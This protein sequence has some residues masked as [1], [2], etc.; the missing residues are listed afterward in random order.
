MNNVRRSAE[1]AGINNSEI[2]GNLVRDENVAYSKRD[3]FVSAGG[4]HTILEFASEEEA[5]NFSY[6][7]SRKI[8]KMFPDMELF[9]KIMP[10]DHSS[11]PK[12][13]INNLI[14]ELEIKKSL[15]RLS[16]HKG[17]FGIEKSL[18]AI[19]E[20]DEEI[21]AA[22]RSILK[23]NAEVDDTLFDDTYNVVKEF[24]NLGGS[25]GDN[26]Y[27]AVVHIDGN[28]MGNRVNE[29][30]DACM[31]EKLSWEAF[32]ERLDVFSEEIDKDF[33]AA[34]KE[35][36]A[37]I[38]ESLENGT[39]DQLDLI[40]NNFPV[41]RIISS[42]DD[43]CFVCDGRIGIEAAV[44]FIKA[45]TRRQNI[46]DQKRYAACAG[47]A[48][49][50]AKYPFYRAYQLAED[51]C[52]NAKKVGAEI[53]EEVA[54]NDKK[55]SGACISAIDWHIEQGELK[56]HLEDI[57]NDYKTLDGNY[58]LLR[59]Y[60]V[61]VG[62]KYADQIKNA[63][64]SRNYNIFKQVMKKAKAQEDDYIR[65]KL[66]E[67]RPYLKQGDAVARAFIGRH[68]LESAV[69]EMYSGI[70]KATDISKIGTGTKLCAEL[71][72]DGRSV[73]KSNSDTFAENPYED[74]KVK[75]ATFY[76]EIE[77]IDYYIDLEGEN[78]ED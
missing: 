74:K 5:Q 39:L 57:R 15:R 18:E 54:G 52:S 34:F 66:K 50:H 55:E 49:V 77:A 60:I 61:E 68:K 29:F 30:Y 59:P 10:Y 17:N 46:V 6:I 31:K 27:I 56:D 13:N 4:G 42:G 11:N 45:L 21:K 35:M 62:G 70:F 28:G 53:F 65:G 58:L 3:N 75:Y 73:K 9:I 22:K 12:E 32:K 40:E 71:F 23:R 36:N 51:L 33:K 8:H 69:L 20:D 2:I 72:V 63:Y 37:V 76:D 1:I 14:K 48:I 26:N 41:R 44:Q 47:V 24:R 67:M 19:Q 16:F 78:Y 25:Y 38:G 43:I 7:F 64:S